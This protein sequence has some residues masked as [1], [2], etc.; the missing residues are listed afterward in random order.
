VP[1]ISVS[2][3]LKIDL[4][5]HSVKNSPSSTNKHT[6]TSPLWQTTGNAR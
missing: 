5:A 3:S 6:V 2:H 1:Y 4:S